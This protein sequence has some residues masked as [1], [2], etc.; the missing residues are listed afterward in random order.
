[1]SFSLTEGQPK[2]EEGSPL[3]KESEAGTKVGRACNLD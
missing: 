1:M 3:G 2:A